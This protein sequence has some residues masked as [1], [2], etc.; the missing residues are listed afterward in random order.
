[1]N[2]NVHFIEKKERKRMA[3]AAAQLYV[4][5]SSGLRATGCLATS[6]HNTDGLLPLLRTLMRINVAGS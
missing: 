6:E 5:T 1:M 2:F 3:V 4:G